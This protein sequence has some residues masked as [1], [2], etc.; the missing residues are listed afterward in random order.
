MGEGRE[1]GGLRSLRSLRTLPQSTS[2]RY[3]GTRILRAP[4]AARVRG[5]TRLHPPCPPPFFMQK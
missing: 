4:P 5:W 1:D 3:G 2:S